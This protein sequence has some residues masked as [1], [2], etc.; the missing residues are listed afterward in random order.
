MEFDNKG[1]TSLSDETIITALVCITVI[2][3]VGIFA[4]LAYLKE[5]ASI[6]L[7]ED[8]ISIT[9]DNSSDKKSS[10]K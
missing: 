2:G 6:T 10:K 4:I 5:K 9:A 7:R 1:V 8:E 3:V